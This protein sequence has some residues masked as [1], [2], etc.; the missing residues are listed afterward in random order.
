MALGLPARRTGS[1]ARSPT[2]PAR[3]APR[4]SSSPIAIPISP[5]AEGKVQLAAARAG[6]VIGGG[7]WAE[8]R[9]IPDAMRAFSESK[10]LVVRNPSA[11]RPWQHVLEPLSGYLRLAEAP[12]RATPPAAPL[13]FN[14]GAQRRGC[15]RRCARSRTRSWRAGRTAPTWQ[16][17]TSV[18]PYEARLLEVDSAKAR[19]VLGWAPRW[20]LRTL[21]T[22]RSTGTKPITKARTCRPSR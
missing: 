13:A 2:A 5:R 22:A 19:T 21:S 7:D 9:L 15:R 1:A 3:P 17:D 16:H 14:F 18:Q 8:D 6:N 4:S 12:A 20:R 10:P 11:V